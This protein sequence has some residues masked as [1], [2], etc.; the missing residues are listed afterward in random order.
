M[1]CSIKSLKA[2]IKWTMSRNFCKGIKATALKSNIGSN[3]V[4]CNCGFHIKQSD[5]YFNNY[6]FQFSNI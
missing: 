2:I 1:N 4:L 6:I 5:N 3:K